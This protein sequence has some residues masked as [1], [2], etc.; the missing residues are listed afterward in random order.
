MDL[1]LTGG[2]ASGKSTV[3]NMLQE[4][5]AKI[6][7]ADRISREIVLPGS[8][9]LALIAEEFGSD[10]IQQ[11]GTLDRKKLGSIIFGDKDKRLK[12]NAIMHPKI[13]EEMRRRISQYEV[14]D[15]EGLV[16]AD[17]PLLYESNLQQMF[18]EV[19]VVY[20]PYEVQLQRLMER[21]QLSVA[22]AE[23]RIASQ[24][25]LA[26]KR[27]QADIVIDNSRSLQETAIQIEQ[28]LQRK[29]LR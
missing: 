12:L 17:I 10:V 9:V 15:P 16:V 25:P 28:Y 13:R 24:M 20:V 3:S 27:E 7:D 18:T 4:R 11:D 29:G 5:G 23:E 2:I 22:E 26:D 21:D 6:V 14:E 1:G 19:M 8:P